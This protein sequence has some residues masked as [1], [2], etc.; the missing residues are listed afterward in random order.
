MS[1]KLAAIYAVQADVCKRN[2]CT[3]KA[4]GA[5]GLCALFFGGLMDKVDARSPAWRR[6]EAHGGG[7]KCARFRCMNRPAADQQFCKEH[8]QCA[9]EACREPPLSGGRCAKHGG[10]DAAHPAAVREPQAAS[11][12]SDGDSE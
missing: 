12:S 11:G 8:A 9:I 7:R 10:T 3:N 6:C 2:L 4:V 5:A 1:D